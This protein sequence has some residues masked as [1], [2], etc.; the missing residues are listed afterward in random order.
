MHRRYDRTRCP[1]CRR[2]WKKSDPKEPED[3]ALGRSRGG[4]STK[5]HLAYDANGL[6]LHFE[7]TPGQGHENTS[8]IDLLNGTDEQVT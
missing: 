5:I 4:F 7:I 8:L 2:R 3:H 1:M 6:P